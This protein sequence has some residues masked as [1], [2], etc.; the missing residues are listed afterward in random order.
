MIS[1][2]LLNRLPKERAYKVGVSADDLKGL[3][4]DASLKAD[5]LAA[6]NSDNRIDISFGFF[7][8]NQLCRPGE[9]H[10]FDDALLK[11]SLKLLSTKEWGIRDNCVT[12]ISLLGQQLSN[13]R[14]L[15]LGA[16]QDKDPLVRKKALL[17]YH[18]FSKRKEIAPLEL[19]EH[20]DFAG[21][22]GMGSHLVYELR[23]LALETIEKK[24]GKSFRKYE[25]IGVYKNGAMAYWWDWE[26]FHKWKKSFWT[27]L[28][29]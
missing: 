19:F 22:V 28:S 7:F 10:Q 6:L 2:K 27:K 13:Y 4:L 21:E 8:V 15:M 17:A 20:D 3:I 24:I 1:D 11:A 5:I 26:P 23:N 25:K 16:L 18:T 29:N 12:I 9:D 14:E